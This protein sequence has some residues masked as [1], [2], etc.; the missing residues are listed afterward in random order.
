[1]GVGEIIVDHFNILGIY[2][3]PLKRLEPPSPDPMKAWH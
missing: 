1:M 3:Y 2:E